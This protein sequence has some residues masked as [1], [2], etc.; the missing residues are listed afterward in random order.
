MLEIFKDHAVVTSVVAAIS[1]VIGSVL[2]TFFAPWVKHKLEL[3]V[4]EQ[5]EKSLKNKDVWIEG[6]FL[7]RNPDL[8]L[9]QDWEERHDYYYEKLNWWQPKIMN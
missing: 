3:F 9:P 7:Y 1:F 4:M 6:A 2:T 5:L 8:D